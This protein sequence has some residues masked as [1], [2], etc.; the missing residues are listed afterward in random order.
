MQSKQAYLFSEGI[1][2]P[3]NVEP[4]WVKVAE[5][6]VLVADSAAPTVGANNQPPGFVVFGAGTTSEIQK[7]EK[8]TS[9]A[10]DGKKHHF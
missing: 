9:A 10:S 2:S 5:L 6:G 4:G 7:G 1:R 8:N 3:P